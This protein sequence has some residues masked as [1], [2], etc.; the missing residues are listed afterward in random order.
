M[1]QHTHK[2]KYAPNMQSVNNARRNGD[3][4]KT[5]KMRTT[6]MGTERAQKFT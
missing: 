5:R 6:K 3:G 4:I 2:E 1:Q